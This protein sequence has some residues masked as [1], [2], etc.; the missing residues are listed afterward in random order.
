M[1]ATMAHELE[2]NKDGKARFAYAETGGKPWHYLGTPMKG[3]GTV[4]QMLEASQANY[5]VLLTHVAAVD[6]DGNVIRNPDGSPVIIDDSRATIRENLDGSYDGLAT[7]GTR[8]TV[9]QNLEVA[10]RAL[11]VVGASA[12]DAVVD[13]AGVLLDGRRFFMTLDLGSLVIDPTGVNDLIQRYLV[14]SAGHDGVWPVRYANTDIRAVCN[15]TVRLGISQARRVFVARHTKNID[16]LFE[17]AQQVLGMSTD[18]AV[19]FR[20]RAEELLR[21]RI[22]TSSRQIDAVLDRVFPPKKGETERM[23]F[24]RERQNLTI[25]SIYESEKNAGG[26]GHNG[27]SMY[28]A[29]GEYLDHHREAD[30]KMR[31]MASLDDTSWVT[32][33]KTETEA[34]ILAL[35]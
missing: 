26:F 13:T 9:K 31:A 34:A 1:E 12:G 2:I 32:R 21:V 16:D 15:N 30:T 28:S 33:K 10:E 24:Q 18:W 29:V 14:I 20:L 3:L 23:K 6:E 27:W 8:Y 25:R 7:V 22:P 35:V 5:N 4:E 19:G 11:A 17:D